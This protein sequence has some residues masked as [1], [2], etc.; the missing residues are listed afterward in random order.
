MNSQNQDYVISEMNYENQRK[1]N[2]ERIKQEYNNELGKYTENYR[3]YIGKTQSN[4]P[5]DIDEIN[6]KESKLNTD[7]KESNDTLM[8]SMLKPFIEKINGD[9]ESI[10]KQKDLFLKM[11]SVIAKNN[12]KLE[13]LEDQYSR[14]STVKQKN[15]KSVTETK[16]FNNDSI[17]VKNNIGISL[18]VLLLVGIIIIIGVNFS[19]SGKKEPIKELKTDIS[20]MINNSNRK[21][22][23]TKSDGIGN[24]IANFFKFGDSKNNTTTASNTPKPSKSNNNKNE[25]KMK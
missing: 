22:K 18:C 11:E 5:D 19:S 3:M 6:S 17:I 13:Q 12:A 24:K 9:V 14:L 2:M 7:L 23:E 15:K 21:K 4:D 25:I 1:H 16:K 8:N 10:A 20:N